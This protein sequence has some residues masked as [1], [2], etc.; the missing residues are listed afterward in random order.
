MTE[1]DEL[2]KEMKSGQLEIK[3]QN[4][5]QYHQLTQLIQEIV[6]NQKKSSEEAKEDIGLVNQRQDTMEKRLDKIKNG[7]AAMGGDSFIERHKALIEH[8]KYGIQVLGMPGKVTEA[9]AKT[10]LRTELDLTKATR[11][12][13]A[14]TQA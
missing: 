14:I 13:M 12:N 10:Y 2:R 4:W 6:L 9:N 11:D 7:G 3:E 5:E 1:A 8:A